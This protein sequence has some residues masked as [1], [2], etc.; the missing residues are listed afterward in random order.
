MIAAIVVTVATEAIGVAAVASVGT[1]VA[2]AATKV[3]TKAAVKSE[4]KQKPKVALMAAPKAEPTAEANARNAPTGQWGMK[5]FAQSPS[6]SAAVMSRQFANATKTDRKVAVSRVEKVA[7]KI[8]VMVAV[9]LAPSVKP[10]RR[11][12]SPKRLPRK[13]QCHKLLSTTCPAPICLTLT[14]PRV[15]FKQRDA[16]TAVVVGDGIVTKTSKVRLT[17]L[18]RRTTISL[19]PSVRLRLAFSLKQRRRLP[20]TTAGPRQ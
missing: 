8:A 18:L 1:V 2:M 3:E 13:L 5:W 11:T 19:H 14:T 12:R 4:V 6:T 15:K 9:A 7:A 20:L 16:A 10:V 17:H